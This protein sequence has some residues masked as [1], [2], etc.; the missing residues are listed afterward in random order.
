MNG[1]RRRLLDLLRDVLGEHAPVARALDF[2]AGDGWFACEF[3]RG[4][5]AREVVAVDVRPREQAVVPT[6]VYDG[7]RLPFAD[8]AFDLVSSIDVLHHCPDPR[9]SLREALRC[10]GR[11]F[12][13][14][15]HTYRGLAG[16]LALCVLD[17]VGNRRFG[18]PSLYHYQ[19]AHEWFPTIAGA[20]FVLRRLVHPA[21][22]HRGVLGWATNRLQFVGLWERAEAPAGSV[23][24]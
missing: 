11:F 3:G 12:L 10:A 18:V 4:G 7:R 2:G 23:A 1:Y 21:P 19:R 6:L 14:K 16:K 13:L 20:G 17:E 5:L 22:C 24:V 9:A 8:R 15:D